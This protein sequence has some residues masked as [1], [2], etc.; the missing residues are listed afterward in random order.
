[1]ISVVKFHIKRGI[2]YFYV[3][4]VIIYRFVLVVAHAKSHMCHVRGRLLALIDR[5]ICLLFLLLFTQPNHFAARNPL[6]G[7]GCKLTK[8]TNSSTCCFLISRQKILWPLT[9]QL[10]YILSCAVLWG[11][12]Q[13]CLF[14]LFWNVRF[15]SDTIDLTLNISELS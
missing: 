12:L 5:I 13:P 6:P 4:S 9:R 11:S 8:I 7:A 15:D 1:M 10:R 14:V 2:C 3:H